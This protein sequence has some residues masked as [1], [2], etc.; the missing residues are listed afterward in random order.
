[1]V[2]HN[3]I[4]DQDLVRLG[5]HQSD[6]VFK[7]GLARGLRGVFLQSD[8]VGIVDH[9]AEFA[10]F[11]WVRVVPAFEGGAVAGRARAAFAGD[12]SHEGE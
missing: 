9:A 1:M 10:G 4:G 3:L 12:D 6:V 7:G 11:G 5:I 8:V 2:L